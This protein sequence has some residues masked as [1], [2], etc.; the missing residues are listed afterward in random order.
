MAQGQAGA[1][2]SVFT[3]LSYLSCF[4]GG[5]LADQW[6]GRY[7]T[8][9]IFATCYFVGTVMVAIAAQPDVLNL[10]I[11]LAGCLVFI[12]IGTGA[13][14]PNVMTFGAAQYDESDPIERAEQKTFFSY[15]YMMINVG[16]GVSFGFLVNLT[17]AAI[18]PAQPDHNP[19]LPA[20]IGNGFFTCYVIAAACMGFAVLSF[21][22]GTCRYKKEPPT[23][24]KPMISVICKYMCRSATRSP[25]G[26]MAVIGWMLI[27]IY[28]TLNL[29]GS[30][31]ASSTAGADMTYVCL[32]LCLI[33]S[34]FLVLGHMNNDWMTEFTQEITGTGVTLVDA[35]K[36]CSLVP[37]MLLINIGFN[38]AYN[39]MNNAYPALACQMDLRLPWDQ[40]SQLNGAFTNLGDCIAI[41]VGV[42]I[43]ESLIYPMIERRR[44][45]AIP[46]RSKYIVGFLLACFANLIAICIELVRAGRDFIPN[47]PG[48]TDGISKCAPPKL[49]IHMSDMSCFWVFIPMFITGIGEILVNPVVYEF[50]FAEAPSQLLSVVQAFN[51]VVA[52]SISNCITGPLSIL[53]FPNNLNN[54]KEDDPLSG[55][56]GQRGSVNITFIV[57]MVIGLL[58][59]FAYLLV[60]KYDECEPED[61]SLK[62]EEG[63][64]P[65]AAAAEEQQSERILD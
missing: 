33:S 7:K 16:A 56:P 15:F 40:T 61:T 52:G 37:Q 9:L 48:T 42:P 23:V 20:Y 18:V 55:I 2:N 22:A 6:L 60:E 30:I 4:L 38:V 64:Q 11:Y 54:F 65:L 17:T 57:N 10:P 8:I 59:L 58:C 50:A 49:A 47:S 63:E 13:I 34:V 41:I 44:G 14:K 1:I 45:K 19:P 5:Y 32:V 25:R 27:P 43:I 62:R 29:V 28:I 21:L 3:M 53:V 26:M 46:R 35:K 12:S 51:L 39:A 36:V 31:E 24:H